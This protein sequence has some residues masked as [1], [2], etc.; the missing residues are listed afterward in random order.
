MS[1]A[2]LVILVDVG[3]AA[4][5]LAVHLTGGSGSAVLADMGHVRERFAEDFADEA[6][7]G[8]QLCNDGQAAF[9]ELDA[10]RTG[11]IQAFGDRFLTR[12][13]TADDVAD[14]QCA[15]DATISIRFRD[16]TWRG[17]MF[18][19]DDPRIAKHM[20]RRLRTADFGRTEEE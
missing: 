11:I 6:V 4:I 7:T 18:A 3:I 2:Y 9:L 14:I 17:G 16:F 15:G 8:V 13:V 10:G 20:A 12:I 5:V 1:L 19:F